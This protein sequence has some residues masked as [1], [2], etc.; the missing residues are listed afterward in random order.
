MT[1]KLLSDAFWNASLASVWKLA[2]EEIPV[3]HFTTDALEIWEPLDDRLI[4]AASGS[5][6]D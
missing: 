6:L 1:T 3:H 5:F 4:M 2:A